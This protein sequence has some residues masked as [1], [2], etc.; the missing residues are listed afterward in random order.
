M[1]ITVSTM[2]LPESGTSSHLTGNIRFLQL[3]LRWPS[4]TLQQEW[5]SLDLSTGITTLEWRDVPTVV[6]P[7]P[8]ETP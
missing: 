1:T 6:S 3:Q 2:N 7:P 4:P 5:A 8:K